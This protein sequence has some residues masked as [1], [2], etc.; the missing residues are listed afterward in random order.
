VYGA[1]ALRAGVTISDGPVLVLDDTTS[2]GWTMTVVA[3]VL[4][5]AGASPVYPLVL[6]RE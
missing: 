2:S 3:D 5:S 1:F 4:G 6:L